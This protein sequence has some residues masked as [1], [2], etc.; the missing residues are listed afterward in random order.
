MGL[1]NFKVGLDTSNF[2]A[3]LKRMRA[4]FNGWAKSAAS[5]IG[6]QIAGAM[7][8]ERVVGSVASLYQE[9]AE[10]QRQADIRGIS[11]DQ[12]QRLGKAAALAGTDIETVLD[13]IDEISDKRFEALAGNM[14]Y[15]DIFKTY[16]QEFDDI[17]NMPNFELFKNMVTEM[18]GADKSTLMR[19][20]DELASDA[21]KRIAVAVKNGMFQG[22]SEGAVA[23][24]PDQIKEYSE[25]DRLYKEQMFALK[26]AAVKTIDLISSGIGYVGGMVAGHTSD[27]VSVNNARYRHNETVLLQKKMEKHL[28][29]IKQGFAP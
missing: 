9:A 14:D 12:F 15:M 29:A 24:N 19:H 23:F 25:T 7:A 10:I 22:I 1:L 21:G 28:E 6:G 8:L 2:N 5:G 26:G 18:E 16:G 3:G 17:A 27:T 4:G 11:T 20:L 13:A